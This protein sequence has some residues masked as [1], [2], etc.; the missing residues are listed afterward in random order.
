M[1]FKI[2]KDEYKELIKKYITETTIDYC[3]YLR[4]KCAKYK[5]VCIFG[6]GNIGLYSQ[7]Q[8]KQHNITVDFFCDNNS[9]KWGKIYNDIP[10]ISLQELI[11]I[12][13]E[14]IVFIQTRYYKEIYRQLKNLGFANLDRILDNRFFIG[15]FLG[16]TDKEYVIDHLLQVIDIL[17]DEESC[18]ILT[19]IVQ[20]WTRNEYTYGQLDDIHMEPQYF[21]P[22]LVNINAED[23]FVDCGAYIGD[24]LEEY[25]RYTAGKFGKVYLFE[26]SK[27]NYERLLQNIA[28]KF[29]KYKGEL[30][31]VNKGVAGE[32]CSIEYIEGDEGSKVSE[33]EE[34]VNKVQGEVVTLDSFFGSEKVD[35][36]KMDIEGVELEAIEGAHQIIKQQSP[37][38]AVCLYHKPE[39]IWEIPLRIKDIQ[40]EYNI[41]IR[42]HTDL[43]N[44]TVC[45][46][47]NNRRER[48]L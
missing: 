17:E 28:T 9:E 39:D 21:V 46:A 19:R 33:E 2:K 23:T 36:I 25:V 45:Y 3:S 41:Y 10:C 48:K 12:K 16:K 6:I 15:E 30:Y 35:F 26:L 18:R 11:E 44:E 34:K 20:E 14:T 27:V 38:L 31:A 47:V 37:T 43:L 42:H 4:E 40:P 32:N 29:A 22:E 1:N 24:T 13:D 8:L 7:Y 5:N